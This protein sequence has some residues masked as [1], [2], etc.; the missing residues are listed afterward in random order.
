MK[1]TKEVRANS[2]E[3]L[4]RT[5]VFLESFWPIGIV[6]FFQIIWTKNGRIVNLLGVKVFI[7]SPISVISIL[8]VAVGIA[9]KMRIIKKDNIEV[10]I[11]RDGVRVRTHVD[12]NSAEG[13]Y[14]AD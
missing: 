6:V 13:Y 11:Y 4:T 8:F 7:F 1:R 3:V 14:F 12:V 5:D 2:G 10:G 9:N